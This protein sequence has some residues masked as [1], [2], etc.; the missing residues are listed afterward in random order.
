[1]TR[2]LRKVLVAN[3]GEIAVRIIRAC[4][5]EGV[6]TVAVASEADMDS[7]AV[8]EAD[9]VVGIG[10][11]SAA[12]SYLNV[13][14]IVCAALLADCDAVHP[15][16]GFLSEQPELVEACDRFGLTFVG[17]TADTIRAA[18]DKLQARQLARELGVPLAAGSDAVSDSEGVAAL[19]A[20]LGLPVL[21]KAAAG[22][23]GRGM[24]LVR[25]LSELTESVERARAEALAAFGDDRLFVERFVEQAR[26]VEVQILGDAHGTVVHL[27]DRDCSYQRRYQKVVEEAPAAAIPGEV[28]GALWDAARDLMRAL[29]YVGAGTVEF[30]VDVRRGTFAFLEINT[31]VQ[32]EHPITEMVTGIDIVRE[33]LRIAAGAP[34]SFAQDDVV[35]SGHAIEFRVN[36]ESPRHDF[37]P[38]PGTI[39]SWNEPAGPGVRVDTHCFPGYSVPAHYDSLLAKLIV[40]AED[41]PTALERAQAAL[42]DFGVSGIETTLG[43]HR[44]LLEHRDVRENQVSTRWLE[45]TFLPTWSLGD[46]EGRQPSLAAAAT[47]RISHR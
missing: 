20:D 35:L 28:R 38:T 13:G 44:A 8:R 26:H 42:A 10:A 40:W 22:G 37:L 27:G 36:A 41:R 6:R 2:G 34:L 25:E 29:G 1:M 14:A 18:G 33:Q 15:G 4:R 7:L 46:D 31:R 11:A 19:V 30:L 43:L 17:P 5:E 3:R 12:S 39:Q 23:G 32:V 9:E 24:R 47:E 21:L 16:Y 45:E